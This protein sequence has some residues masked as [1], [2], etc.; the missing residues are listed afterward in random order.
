[1]SHEDK[2]CEFDTPDGKSIALDTFTPRDKGPYLC[3]S[4]ACP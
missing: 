3:A 1:M 2:W 4:A